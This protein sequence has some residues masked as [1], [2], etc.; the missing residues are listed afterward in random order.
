MCMCSGH[1]LCLVASPSLG[2][3]VVGRRQGKPWGCYSGCQ[4][5]YGA[6]GERPHAP[7]AV[8]LGVRKGCICVCRSFAHLSMWGVV[9]VFNL[10]FRDVNSD[11]I[12]QMGSDKGVVV[13]YY[14]V[15]KLFTTRNVSAPTSSHPHAVRRF[16]VGSAGSKFRRP[17]VRSRHHVQVRSPIS[18]ASWYI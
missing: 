9:D 18:T 15:W 13:V 1:L 6:D 3:P 5:E 8:A 2:W 16:C 14:L 11:R 4:A 17:Q 7:R 12:T 10:G